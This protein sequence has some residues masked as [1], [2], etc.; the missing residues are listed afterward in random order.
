VAGTLLL[1]A[2]L[3][4]VNPAGGATALILTLGSEAATL[5]GAVR[6]TT[7]VLLVTAL[8]EGARRLSLMLRR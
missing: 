4:A 5:A 1:Q 2:L 7:A 8:G 3:G 6:L